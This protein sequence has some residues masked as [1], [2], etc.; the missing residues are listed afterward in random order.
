MENEPKAFRKLYQR[1]SIAA[2]PKMGEEGMAEQAVGEE[3]DG[4][5]M[6][7]INDGELNFMLLELNVGECLSAQ[8]AL[9]V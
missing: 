7:I 8:H 3:T 6:T 1:L 4:V 2:A 5:S 9:R